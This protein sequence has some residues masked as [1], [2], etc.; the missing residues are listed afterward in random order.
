MAAPYFTHS[1]RAV[2]NTLITDTQ[3]NDN[4]DAVQASFDLLPDP[5]E[6]RDSLITYTTASNVANAYNVIVDG[7]ISYKP[8]TTIRMQ[9]QETNT[10]GNT[11]L[12]I[13]NLPDIIILRDNLTPI[14]AGD[15]TANS[16]YTVAYSFD[17][18]GFVMQ[19]APS[20]I[21]SEVTQLQSDIK[22]S[23]C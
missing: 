14:Q 2:K 13:N 21:V 12:S 15:L 5:A 7:L 9:V 17:A 23:C 22:C 4:M 20:A 10:A 11:T 19:T 6:I 16:I 8:G 1:D 3:Y 18:S